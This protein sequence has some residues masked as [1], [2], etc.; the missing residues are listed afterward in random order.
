[1]QELRSPL[2]QGRRVIVR[3]EPWLVVDAERF[4]DVAVVALRGVGPD[5]L[6]ETMSVLSPFDAVRAPKHQTQIVPRPRRETLQAAVSAI[7]GAAEWSNCWTAAQAAIEL[8][9]WQLAPARAVLNGACRVLIADEVGLGKT[10]E[11]LLI[12]TELRARGLARRILVLTP[13]S[14]R[15]QWAHEARSR[16]G[17]SATVFDQISLA[18]ATAALPI[19]VN[20]WVT[21]PLII[22]SIDLVKRPE[23]RAAL[24]EVAPDV[25]IVDEAHH[26]T[27]GTDRGAVVADLATRTPWVVLLTAT[28]HSGDDAAFRYLCGL[29]A[30]S[31]DTSDLTTF[32]RR[33][34]D[35]RGGPPRRIHRIA[36]ATTAEERALLD[37]TV[38]YAIAVWSGPGGSGARLVASVIARRAASWAGA[39]RH[40]LERR[41]ALIAG[42][43]ASELQPGLPWED[44][45]D[46]AGLDDETLATP[47]LAAR[48]DETAWLQRLIV[49]AGRAAAQSSKLNL[50]RR[51][52][53]RTREHVLIF[54][55]YRDVA[56]SIAAGLRDLASVAVL[57]GA[58]TPA[59]RQ[60]VTASFNGGCLR[61]LVATD[62]AGE[63]VN[64]QCRCRLVINVELPWSPLRLEQRI[65][66][67]DRIGQTRRVHAL[68]LAH[69]DSFEDTVLARLD[70]RRARAER[71]AETRGVASGDGVAAAILGDRAI[72]L[73]DRAAL[74]TFGIGFDEPRDA[75]VAEHLR[76]FAANPGGEWSA[77]ALVTTA[78]PG[79]ASRSAAVILLFGVDVVD[80][81]Q[82]IVQRDVVALRLAC[83]S[84]A[85]GLSMSRVRLLLRRDDVHRAISARMENRLAAADHSVSRIAVGLDARI[86]ALRA[87][88]SRRHSPQ[89]IQTSLFDRREEQRSRAREAAV[90]RWM[91]HLDRHHEAARS[92]PV[93][94][95]QPPRLVA[96]WIGE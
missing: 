53:R 90:S 21:A 12:F 95:A 37:E 16:F 62:A 81:R 96:A 10:I 86:A 85:G 44:C 94:T 63:G 76:V 50:I 15:D 14:I 78:P 8:R 56:L 80:G 49:L 25:L 13:A 77:D 91:A 84:A 31:S 26:L 33:S 1:M 75:V 19:G 93:L 79:R 54:S 52:L 47:G 57:H 59:E 61:V 2:Q 18:A 71:E 58:L 51:L 6:G 92:L 24:D 65:G 68:H 43:I 89:P 70:A 38:A 35:V 34:Q 67:V 30:A 73:D 22:T 32:R 69:R 74:P 45:S 39:A 87:A 29:G 83:P 42:T 20:P 55:E 64:L 7:S 60:H 11:A 28:P 17:L 46:E 40:T 66:R 9:A 3:D 27:P 4:D 5:N 36:V 72:A 48:N 41:L 23:V 82:Q 88:I